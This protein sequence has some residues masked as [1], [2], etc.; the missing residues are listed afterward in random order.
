MSALS[1]DIDTDG[2]LFLILFLFVVFEL[3]AIALASWMLQI[4]RS[5]KGKHRCPSFWFLGGGVKIS[6]R[7]ERTPSLKHFSYFCR[8][9]K[10]HF[11]L[12]FPSSFPIF[13]N[14]PHATATTHHSTNLRDSPLT[15]NHTPPIIQSNLIL[16]K[17][18]RR[19]SSVDTESNP[20]SI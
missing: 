19:F 8:S 20:L 6:C 7:I 16:H 11:W 5:Q 2:R 18:F 14:S 17:P 3:L 1:I 15:F 9:C 12:T 4:E 10:S 13:Q